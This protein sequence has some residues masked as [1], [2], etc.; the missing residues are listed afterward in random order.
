M[1]RNMFCIF[2]DGSRGFFSCTSYL[3][4]A[5]E[6]WV[7]FFYYYFLFSL[8]CLPV[9]FFFAQLSNISGWYHTLPRK[10]K[11]RVYAIVRVS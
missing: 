2:F 7:F 3:S 10:R 11:I 5:I 4:V 1:S 9:L 8:C 6:K